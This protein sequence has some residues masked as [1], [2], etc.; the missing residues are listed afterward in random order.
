MTPC[1]D[2]LIAL[3][4]SKKSSEAWS[5][6]YRIHEMEGVGGGEVEIKAMIKPIFVDV[7]RD[8]SPSSPQFTGWQL[9]GA[10]HYALTAPTK[11]PLH[12]STACIGLS[13][14]SLTV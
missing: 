3:K 5:D 9:T 13:C 7:E 8:A 12:Q 4:I 14:D 6:A 2:I 11:R 10:A 1:R